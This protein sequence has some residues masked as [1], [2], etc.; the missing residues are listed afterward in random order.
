MN[1]DVGRREALALGASGLLGALAT[2]AAASEPDDLRKTSAA[3]LAAWA[4]KDLDAISRHVHPEVRFTG[5]MAQFEGRDAFLQSS[6]RIFTLLETFEVRSAFVEGE[7]GMFAYDFVCREPIG[8]CRTAELVGFKGGLI[9]EI[10]LLYDARPFEAA[11]RAA[12][13]GK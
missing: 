8:R 5:P 11:L 6:R 10:E 9:R 12:G 4:A 7:R 3:Y 1:A 2:P 13:A